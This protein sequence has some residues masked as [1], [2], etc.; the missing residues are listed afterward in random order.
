MGQQQHLR[1][2]SW[3]SRGLPSGEALWEGVSSDVTGASERSMETEVEERRRM[4]SGGGRCEV[5]G[6]HS[7]KNAFTSGST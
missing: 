6:S 4:L 7:T 1:K 2:G 3:A 5:R